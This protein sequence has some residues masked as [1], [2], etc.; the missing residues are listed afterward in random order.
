M[1]F[2]ILNNGQG[3][4]PFSE[5]NVLVQDGPIDEVPSRRHSN[6][7]KQNSFRL[8]DFGCVTKYGGK[9]GDLDNVKESVLHLFQLTYRSWY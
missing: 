5:L 4:C 1:Y 2:K 3:L 7:I 9:Q 6:G 8:T